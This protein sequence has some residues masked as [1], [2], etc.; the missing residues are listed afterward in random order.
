MIKAVDEYSN[1][2]GSI[3]VDVFGFLRKFAAGVTLF[4][5]RLR[6]RSFGD[7]P[8]VFLKLGG[9]QAFLASGFGDGRRGLSGR[10]GS[11]FGEAIGGQSLRFGRSPRRPTDVLGALLDLLGNLLARPLDPGNGLVGGLPHH[12]V[13]TTT[14]RQQRADE[15]AQRHH[16]HSQCQR[17]FSMGM[18]SAIRCTLDARGEL[19]AA[20]TG[21]RAG[22]PACAVTVI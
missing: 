4:R 2:L 10:I 18:L 5:F 6:L 13:F 14:S 11:S 21:H 19:F 7:F 1:G 16:T 20:R 22:P 17:G 15:R 3:R 9:M 12:F 8:N